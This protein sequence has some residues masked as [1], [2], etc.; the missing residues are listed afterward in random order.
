MNG[1]IAF[2]TQI[3]WLCSL[4]ISEDLSEGII[5]DVSVFF[6]NNQCL[7][8]VARYVLR[9]DKTKEGRRINGDRSSSRPGG[10]LLQE[11]IYTA[12]ASRDNL[13]CGASDVF[14]GIF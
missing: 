3:V 4:A 11:A 10:S 8:V 2:R 1:A 6:K 5:G 12:G 13:S 14:P 7:E 9:R